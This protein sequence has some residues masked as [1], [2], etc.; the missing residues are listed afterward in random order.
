[1][2]VLDSDPDNTS[3]PCLLLLHGFPELAFSWRKI[4]PYL[5]NS[6]YRVIAPDQRGFGLTKGGNPDFNIELDS[7]R[8][9]N[10]V[11]DIVGLLTSLRIEKLQSIVGHDF[12]SYV[13]AY[14]SLIRPDLFKSVILMSM[15]FAG[16]PILSSEDMAGGCT[17]EKLNRQLSFLQKPR[18]HYQLYFSE[19]ETNKD[20]MNCPQGLHKFL[21]AYFHFKS[22][23]YLGNNPHPLTSWN[24]DEMAK[25]PTY[26]IMEK[27]MGMPETVAQ[28]MPNEE[29]IAKCV[30]L[31][32][33]EL[34]VYSDAFKSTGFQGGLNWY[35]ARFVKKFIKEQ[36]IFSGKKIEVPSLFIAGENDW[37]IFQSPGAL[38]KMRTK[39]CSNMLD[40]HLVKNAGH[41]VQQEQPESVAEL[42]NNFLFEIKT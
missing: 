25:L 30:W 10:L 33:E 2:H 27:H 19:S 9:L 17:L 34:R 36:Q 23:D 21:R 29:T 20:L 42:I 12:G 1:M 18:K 35:R 40:C 15:P 32:E 4:F 13:A 8:Y 39:A 14:C 6:G 26:Y 24:A 22:A 5:V 3:K 16:P 11:Q 28:E 41:W 38:E 7:Y 37:G 31:T